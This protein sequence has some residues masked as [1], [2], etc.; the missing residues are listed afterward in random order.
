M[1]LKIRV[2][3]VIVNH[4]PK[5]LGRTCVHQD[6]FLLAGLHSIRLATPAQFD[7]MNGAALTALPDGHHLNPIRMSFFQVIQVAVDIY[8]FL[9]H[10]IKKKVN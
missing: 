2:D 7:D 1:K 3:D 4:T 6:G 5:K 8:F 9:F 10:S